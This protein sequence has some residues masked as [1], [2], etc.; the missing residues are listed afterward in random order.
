VKNLF[1]VGAATFPGPGLNAA[2][3]RIVAQRLL[4]GG[5]FRKLDIRSNF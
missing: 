5:L 1:M 3:G 4:N 2:S